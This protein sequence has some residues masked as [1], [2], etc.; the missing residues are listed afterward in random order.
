MCKFGVGG[1]EVNDSYGSI[2]VLKGMFNYNCFKFF[3][4]REVFDFIVM[5]S[6]Y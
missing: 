6:F 5:D 4:G 2:F 1:D 3:L